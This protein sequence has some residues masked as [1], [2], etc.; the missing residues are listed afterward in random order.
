[1][2]EGLETPEEEGVECLYGRILGLYFI[3]HISQEN[4]FHD[5]KACTYILIRDK[6]HHTSCCT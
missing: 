6:E 1:M 3:V 4:W 5:P 2:G